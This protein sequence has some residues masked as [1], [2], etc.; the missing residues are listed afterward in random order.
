MLD[1]SVRPAVLNMVALVSSVMWLLAM[2]ASVSSVS[3]STADPVAWD[4]V[5]AANDA[6][7]FLVVTVLAWV[8][9]EIVRAI[10]PR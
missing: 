10:D 8:G 2:L 1:Q 7:G 9:A 5:V 4:Y 3:T 6:T